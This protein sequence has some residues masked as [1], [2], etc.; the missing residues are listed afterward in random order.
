V[1]RTIVTMLLVFLTTWGQ[2]VATVPA[3]TPA[4]LLGRWILVGEPV[5][6]CLS[7]SLEFTSDGLLK[8]TS[9]AQVLETSIEITRES[10]GFLISTTLLRHNNEPNCQGRSAMYVAQHFAPLMFARVGGP[11]LTALILDKDRRQH[12]L[13]MEFRRDGV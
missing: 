1:K 7:A 6:G 5:P 11:G 10:G 8:M 12:G 3:V 2:S 9:G 4:E 13:T